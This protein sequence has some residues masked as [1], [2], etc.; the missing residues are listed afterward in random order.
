MRA[1]VVL[2]ALFACGDNVPGIA[3]DEFGEARRTAE[4][5][6]LTRCGLF[7]TQSA[8]ERYLVPAL[9]RDVR[10]AVEAKKMSFDGAAAKQCLDAIAAM[11]CDATSEEARVVP[12]AC[13]RAL[14]GLL[15][16]NETCAFDAECISG[17]CDAP[18]CGRAECC[19]GSCQPTIVDAAP[20][21]TCAR[22]EDCADG[23]CGLDLHCTPRAPEREMCT[24]DE[25][26]AYD[27]AC[28]GATE[29][30]PGRCR[31]LPLLGEACPY[32]RCAEIGASCI[33]GTCVP[34]G[35]AGDPCTGPADC[36]FYSECAPDGFCAE[37]PRLGETC[38]FECELGAWCDD[39]RCVGPI[40]DGAPCVQDAQCSDRF[41]REGA[42]FDYCDVLPTCN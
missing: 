3:L 39:G 27:L 25:E 10:S 8:C 4:C 29:F 28:I 37:R 6:R 21:E 36:S 24:R 15:A 38:T 16:D 5:E 7:S 1:A 11:T 35:L 22:D 41:C 34:V 20:G 23:F 40:E 2:V 9:D 33:N 19:T 13:R 31:D 18:N 26:C 12:L 17:S 32:R 14:G 42:T 30:E